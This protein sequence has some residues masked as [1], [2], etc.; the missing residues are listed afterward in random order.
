VAR[1]STALSTPISPRKSLNN[2]FAGPSVARR[3]YRCA[4]LLVNVQAWNMSSFMLGF[5]NNRQASPLPRN[6]NDRIGPWRSTAAL[7]GK[8]LH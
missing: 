2:R 6:S 7:I 3:S 1:R 4:R 5:T 8:R